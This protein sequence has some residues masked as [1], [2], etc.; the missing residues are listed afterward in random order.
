MRV[1][2]LIGLLFS[3]AL[4]SSCNKNKKRCWECR[5]TTYYVS[6]SDS[7]WEYKYS[8][9]DRTQDEI[10]KYEK[11]TRT[12]SAFIN[13]LSTPDTLVR[14]TYCKKKRNNPFDD[15]IWLHF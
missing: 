14:R 7:T 11:D 2:F 12:D 4:T 13:S 6:K 3:V 15:D 5:A 10:N 8:A 9:C 1:P